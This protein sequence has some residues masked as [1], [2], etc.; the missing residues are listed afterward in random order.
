M[1]WVPL[2]QQQQQQ[3]VSRVK[4]CTARGAGFMGIGRWKLAA[5]CGGCRQDDSGTTGVK[6]LSRLQALVYDILPSRRK[7]PESDAGVWL[8]R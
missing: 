1:A 6:W 8:L 4:I 7:V 5:G 2:K 3:M